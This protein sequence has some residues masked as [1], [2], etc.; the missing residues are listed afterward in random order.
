MR[1][2]SAVAV[3]G[4]VAAAALAT[5]IGMGGVRLI[6]DSLTSTPGGVLDEQ[7]V[8]RALAASPSAGSSSAGVSPSGQFSSS[9]ALPGPALSGAPSAGASS[10]GEPS[11]G[12]PPSISPPSQ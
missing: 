8:A 1:R 4:W 7:D 10:G 12:A 9:A 11:P 5:L 6:G 3:A 2:T